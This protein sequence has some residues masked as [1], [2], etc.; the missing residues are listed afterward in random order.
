MNV[1]CLILTCEWEGPAEEAVAHGHLHD[2]AHFEQASEVTPAAAWYVNCTGTCKGTEGYHLVLRHKGRV[3]CECPGFTARGKC[4]HV[5]AVAD[6]KY[7]PYI[8]DGPLKEMHRLVGVF[9]RTLD[10]DANPA[11]MV[12]RLRGTQQA[13]ATQIGYVA[14][15]KP[16]RA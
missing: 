8:E 13:M 11:L 4:R 1:R 5:K 2:V 12:L 16:K 15:E 6:A 3:H 10:E 7:P 14:P 9:G